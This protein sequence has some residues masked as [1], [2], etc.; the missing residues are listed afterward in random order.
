MWFSL[1]SD[2]LSTKKLRPSMKS[3]FRSCVL[4]NSSCLSQYFPI[5]SGVLLK[6][7]KSDMHSKQFNLYPTDELI[8]L[9]IKLPSSSAG[10]D[11]AIWFEWIIF[12]LFSKRNFVK[13]CIV[14]FSA[15]VFIVYLSTRATKHDLITFSVKTSE[16]SARSFSKTVS[17]SS[18][19]LYGIWHTKF[20][21]SST[22][23][24]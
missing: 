14:V 5:D 24:S 10:L 7:K 3:K 16:Q 6:K 22:K 4:L 1:I 18:Q 23:N 8:G 17:T 19:R 9:S 13:F 12:A 2:K 20:S 11:G 15:L 21:R